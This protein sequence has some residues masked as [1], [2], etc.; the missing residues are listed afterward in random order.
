MEP[1]SVLSYMFAETL[2]NSPLEWDLTNVTD[3]SYFAAITRSLTNPLTF[4]HTSGV[5]NIDGMFLYSTFNQPFSFDCTSVISARQLF[6]SSSFNSDLNLTNT[7][8]IQ[9]F[10]DMFRS[11]PFNQDLTLNTDGAI[12]FYRMFY[13]SA[14][15]SIVT[16]SSTAN[17]QDMGKCSIL[18]RFHRTW[19]VGM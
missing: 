2:F 13:Q 4:T 19:K 8:G 10:E 5:T 11:S 6:Y 7:Q 9:Y 1:G 17:V 14:F 18:L 15:N 16:F 12:S 3:M